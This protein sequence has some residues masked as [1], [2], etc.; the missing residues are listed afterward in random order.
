MTA[1]TE[2][3]MLVR[4]RT[5]FWRA[6]VQDEKATKEVADSHGVEDNMGA[7]FK[8]L[9]PKEALDEGRA[10]LSKARDHHYRNTLPWEDNGPRLLSAVNYFDYTQK[11]Q[12]YAAALKAWVESFKPQ[13]PEWIEK[14]KKKLSGLFDPSEYP[15]VDQLDSRFGIDITFSPLPDAGDFR[16]ALNKDEVNKVRRD[17][18]RDVNQRLEEAM[19]DVWNR[20]Y[21]T[22]G[23]MSD[24]LGNQDGRIFA[25]V[26]DNVREIVAL[27]PKLNITGDKNL[28]KMR[29][30]IDAKLCRHDAAMLRNAPDLRE[31]KAKEAAAILKNM[32]GYVGG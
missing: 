31:Q 27:I 13:Y 10:I 3:A 16:V 29:R 18:E 12:E 19:R 1:I 30:D 15:A 20:L 5:S 22:V 17:I 11:Q 32:A 2:K 23:H 7:Y 28:E 21:V 9:I 24:V 14:A 8:R 26:V 4:Q 6:R 25:S